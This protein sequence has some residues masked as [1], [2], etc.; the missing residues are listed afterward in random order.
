MIDG[1]GKYFPYTRACSL[2]PN[3]PREF[4]HRFLY[5]VGED[6]P[7]DMPNIIVPYICTPAQRLA[8]GISLYQ[9]WSIFNE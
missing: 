6:V 7:R 3:E 5:V 2:C 9:M 4:C 1:P 8:L